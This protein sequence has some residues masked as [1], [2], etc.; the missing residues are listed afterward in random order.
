M[1]DEPITWHHG[2]MARWWA[3]FNLPEDREVDYYADAIGR[4][5]E[6]AL[7]LGCGTGR[8]LVPL[9]DRGLAVD[10]VDVSA[11]MVAHAR[12]A[13]SA[14]GH[15]PALTVQALHELDLPRRYR[16]IFMCGVLGIGGDR[17]RDREALR[18]IHDHLEPDGAL[19]MWHEF[20]YAGLD[21]HGWA[22]WLPTGRSGIPTPWPAIGDRRRTTDG[23]EIELRT[24]LVEHD[25]ILSRHTYETQ[26]RLW[27]N[28]TVVSEETRSLHENLYLAPELLLLLDLAGFRDVRMEA[29]YEGRPATPADDTVI[30]V[31]RPTMGSADLVAE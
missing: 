19:V 16:T 8:L 3:E 29:A 20:P 5:G 12:E 15:T 25:P 23:D 31:A 2:L 24:R 26:A 27:R 10:G 28:G 13:A 9:L 6:P 22:R 17:T 30:V 21:E 11:D 7:D 4:F 18:R 14:A 1:T